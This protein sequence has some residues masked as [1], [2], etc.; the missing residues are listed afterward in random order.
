MKKS[1]LA[2]TAL[3]ALG[4][5]TVAAPASANFEVKLSGYME[6][7]FGYS[8]NDKDAVDNAK[9]F[10]QN[11]DAE[12]YISGKQTLDNG[13]TI[14]FQIE[15][16]AENTTVDND[17]Q[18]A[19]IE[20]SFGKLTLGSENPAGYLMHLATK[21]NGIGVEENDSGFWIAGT[22]GNMN[23]TNVHSEVSDDRNTV[24]YMSPNVNGIQLGVS[25]I[26]TD[27]TDSLSP[28][29]TQR[30]NDSVRDN[31]YSVG[32][33]YSGSFTNDVSLKVAA[34]YSDG[35]NDDGLAGDNTAVTAGIQVGFG[36]F[37]VSGAYGSND[38]D[39]GGNEYSNFATSLAYA[40]GPMGVSITGIFGK[41]DQRDDKQN[42]FELGASYAM[43]PG[44][45]AQA[46]L[47]HV[48][49]KTAGST[50]ANGV[51]AAAGI[52]LDF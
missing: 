16:E 12:Y 11:S 23:R 42:G 9:V 8:D 52:R 17:E 50:A 7:Y 26:P 45:K 44:V 46:S 14:G 32:A 19:Y 39:S 48:N 34:G 49:R 1:L 2:T 35:G 4:A 21:S 22:T 6:Q 28:A 18:Y 5:A 38:N 25:F 15:M 31:G 24:T 10:N 29:G 37:T 41:N 13:L 30:T 40:A 51:A 36:G 20:G 43:G 33:S 47:Y 27:A 3:V